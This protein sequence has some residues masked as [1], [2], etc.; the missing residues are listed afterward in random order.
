MPRSRLIPIVIPMGRGGLNSS[1]NSDTV[2]REDLTDALSLTF[3]Q[4]TVQKE[5]GA[6]K[7]NSSPLAANRRVVGLKE[8]VNGSGT[9]FLIAFVSNG[10]LV[11]VVAGGVGETLASGLT[12]DR[13][14]VFAEGIVSGTKKLFCFTGRDQVRLTEGT[15]ATTAALATLANPADW[16]ETDG[17]TSQPTGGIVHRNRLYGWGNEN[18][19]HRLYF[20][21]LAN[22]EDFTGAG[23]GSLPVYP[24]EGE[25]IA[26]CISFLGRLWVLKYP[27]GVYWVDEGLTSDATSVWTTR[28]LTRNVGMAGPL[29]LDTVE[30]DVLFVGTD[31]LPHLL[32]GVQEFGDARD[33]ALLY[34]KLAPFL[35]DHVA[36]SRLSRSIVTYYPYKKQAHVSLSESGTVQDRRLILDLHVLGRPAATWSERDICEAMTLRRDSNAV[37][38][39][40]VG[41]DTGTVWEL[42][43]L[44]RSKG[45]VGYLGKFQTKPVTLFDGIRRGNLVFLDA[46]MPIGG[47]PVRF[48]LQVERDGK[49]GQTLSYSEALT[50]LILDSGVLDTATLGGAYDEIKVRRRRVT[51][52][53]RV[54][55]LI[56]SNDGNEENFSVSRFILWVSPGNTRP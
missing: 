1:P 33:S 48:A 15:A 18:D 9:Q 12:A 23:S 25:R 26:A 22:H 41:D 13:Q 45:G 17:S 38:R 49:V 52:D 30:G 51:G 47:G 24:G 40:V 5:P 32:S 14:M 2:P 53:A 36:V 7:V 19:P 3:D 10:T 28:R 34:E 55:R 46:V 56:G 31:G 37:Y 29:G 20:S 39:L 27:L 42:D 35:R 54:V 43:R 50:T 44:L 8:F 11:T 4:D 16:A 21:T 6:V